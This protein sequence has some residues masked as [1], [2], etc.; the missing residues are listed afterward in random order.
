MGKKA[1][2]SRKG[3]KEWRANISTDDIHDFFE[4]STKDALSGG[5]LASA[6]AESLFFEDKSKDLSVKRKIEKHRQKVLHVESMLQKNPFV[7]PVPS[8]TLKKSKK[9]HKKVPELM[10]GSEW[11]PKETLAHA[12]AE[13]MGKVYKKELGPQPVPL[14]VPGEAVDEEEMYFLEADEGTDDDMN[15][16]NLDENGDAASEK[17]PLKTKRVTTVVLN[18]RARR[19]EQLKKE[20]EAR[21]AKKLSKEIDGLLL[22]QLLSLEYAGEDYTLRIALSF[23][24]SLPDII[25]EIAK[26]DE[27]R[28]KRHLRRVVAKEE[29]RK[30][31]PPRLGKHKFEPAPIQVLLSEEITGSLRKLKG[32]S[33]LVK[34]R[35]KS[36]EKR[37]LIPPKPNK[38][39]PPDPDPSAFY[40]FPGVQRRTCSSVPP[41]RASEESP[42]RIMRTLA[43][44]LTAYSKYYCTRSP[45]RNAPPRNFSTHNGRDELSL[46]EEAE[47]KIGWM[48]KLI[49]AGTA[50]CVAYNIMPYMGDT[51]LQ[52]SV[53]LLTVKDPLFKRMG[54]SRLAQFAVDDERRMKIVEMGGA[55]ELVNML[56]AA[57]DDITR[58]EALK[59]LTALSPSDK[60]LGAL[61]QAGA[62]PVIRSTPDSLENAEIEKYKSGLLRRFQ[63]QRYDFPTAD[64]SRSLDY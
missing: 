47:R 63:D 61:H 27:E 40:S 16:Q 30:S 50:T 36:L 9:A 28:H 56:G 3:K 33:T 11:S 24:Y 14:T 17:R 60:A 19:K 43:S 34:D 29:K 57:K 38:R 13:E 53:S 32:C 37:G 15:P 12:V 39:K 62:I 55:Q 18:K 46:E 52:Q 22:I 6:P 49:F 4:Q 59:A 51:L 7:Q 41:H 64:V 2:T 45:V 48:L 1:K 31:C 8:S 10:D 35:F 23:G 44:K 20:A 58:K 5:S 26:E 21:E 54:A 42:L 25:E